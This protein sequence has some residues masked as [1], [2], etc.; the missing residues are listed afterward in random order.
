MTIPRLQFKFL[1]F[2]NVFYNIIKHP[3]LNGCFYSIKLIIFEEKEQN[4][5]HWPFYIEQFQYTLDVFFLQTD[6]KCCF[7]NT[8]PWIF[9]TSGPFLVRI[10]FEL[11][12]ITINFLPFQSWS[13]GFIHAGVLK[14]KNLISISDMHV[15][16]MQQTHISEW[17]LEKGSEILVISVDWFMVQMDISTFDYCKFE[18]VY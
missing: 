18:K 4:K 15:M 12:S 14:I 2:S 9:M 11:K 5:I 16:R 6:I 17:W 8:E 1:A 10:S 13:Q 3:F 7:S